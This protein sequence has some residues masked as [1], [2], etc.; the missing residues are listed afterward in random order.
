MTHEGLV[1]ALYRNKNGIKSLSIESLSPLLVRPP[2]F[3]LEWHL[4]RF[5]KDLP[6]FDLRCRKA[7]L[8]NQLTSLTIA[9]N[10]PLWSAAWVKDIPSLVSS[11]PLEYFQLYG[12]TVIKD[13][14]VQLDGFVTS[15]I[16]IH[17][18][19][20]KRFSLHRLPISLKAL[21]DV[22]A[23]FTNLEQLFVVVEQGDLVSPW[24]RIFPGSH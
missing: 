13:E 9:V 7:Q 2:P 18:S 5:L 3:T 1:E 11:S 15:L 6:E 16:S 24:L 20:L 4:T 23:G 10:A 14:E 22:C 17:G 21:D 8:L 12:T 19:R